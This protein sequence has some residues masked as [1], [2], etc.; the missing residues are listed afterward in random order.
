[1]YAERASPFTF[2]GPKRIHQPG[3]RLE[4]LPPIDVILISHNHYDHLD[5]E[6]LTKIVNQQDFAPKILTGLGNSALLN[7]IG[8]KNH[9][10]LNWNGSVKLDGINFTFTKCRHRSGRGITDQMQT[11]WGSFVIE[12]PSGNIYFAGDTGY[13]D[14]F[15]ATKEKFGGFA[16]SILPIGAY[17]PRWFM[18][19][20]HLN[21]AEAVQAHLD[22]NSERSMAI[23]F[24]TF[25]LTLESVEQPV[26]DL[27][28]ALAT[29]QVSEENFL[30]L[31]P[32]ATR[33]IAL[34]K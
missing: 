23:H 22:L 29:N 12:A 13:D 11:L 24:G 33:V 26:I 19:D 28:A 8:L 31:K 7:E 21:P 34:E 16:L 5:T 3:V 15:T 25:Q 30:V 10:E 32:G 14:H 2:A 17:E 1:M 9:N 6:T 4:D 20:V 18:K 27:K